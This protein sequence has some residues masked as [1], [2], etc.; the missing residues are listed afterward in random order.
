VT[1]AGLGLTTDTDKYRTYEATHEAKF[2]N[3]CD[4]VKMSQRSWHDIRKYVGLNQAKLHTRAVELY[5]PS[6]W[7]PQAPML[8]QPSWL[9]DSP[10][11]LEDI[12]LE[13][14][15]NPPKPIIV[16]SEPEARSLLPLRTRRQRFPSY[17]SAIRYLSPPTLFENCPCYRLLG[18]TLSGH[19]QACLQFDQSCYFD[20]IDVSE[21]LV[22][23]LSSAMINA[24]DS[25]LELPFRSPI[26]D[27]FDLVLAL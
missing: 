23:E 19:T 3:G 2:D 21:V 6:W 4:L 13:R 1:S 7:L 25:R 27:P 5:A 11:S 20:K 14:E 17:S 24:A 16:G 10:I 26:S 22:H 12:E 18:A 9:P 15:P 8:S